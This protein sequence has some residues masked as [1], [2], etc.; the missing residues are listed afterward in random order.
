MNKRSKSQFWLSI[1]QLK[2]NRL[3]ILSFWVLV[4]L[5][6]GA[7]FADFISPYSYDN[8]DR[9]YSYCPPTKIH[10]IN[11]QGKIT[12]PF[13]YDKSSSFDQYKRRIYKEDQSKIYP[14]KFLASKDKY[15]LLG[16]IPTS[17]HLFSVD[18]KARIFLWGADY[19]GRDLFSR[20]LYGSRV[21]LSIGLVAVAISLLFGLIIG[22]ISGYYAG[23]IDNI[24]MR[25][26]EMIMMIPG[27]YLM[28]AL[29]AAFPPN[30]TS[31]QVYILIV[32]IFSFIGWAGMARV[33]RGMSISLR[34]REYVLAARALG[35]S[36][37]KIIFRHILPHTI[38][39]TVVAASLSIPG[40]ILGE[41][42]LSLIGLGIQDPHASWGNLLSEAMGIMQIK[43]YPW[44]LLPGLFIFIA[45][46][47]FNLLGDGLRD[48][49]DPML[50]E[51]GLK[52]VP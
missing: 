19:R 6:L 13:I 42:G 2:K 33:I 35:V 20:I 18:T 1:Q 17:I 11:P 52:N 27:F 46:M 8:E 41:S 31:L 4:L 22:G 37:I 47:T 10:F 36:N 50:K 28:L 14:L 40:Y 5:Y 30:L 16:F 49:L 32:L 3:A 34:E 23:K 9:D 7:I 38:S 26:C 21:S 48:A 12:R 39:Y 25:I 24:I 15:K 29:R 44:I 45:V 43:F 51:E